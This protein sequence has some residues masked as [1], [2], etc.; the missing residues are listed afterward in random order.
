[1]RKII[2]ATLFF[3]TQ[4][5]AGQLL[6]TSP[7]SA[8]GIGDPINGD[9]SRIFSIGGTSAAVKDG[10]NINTAN[11][12]SYS[13]LRYTN[14]D[15][16][17]IS[18][19]LR[20]QQGNMEYENG[21]TAFNYI[22]TS[23][24]LANNLSMMMGIR[25]HTTRGFDI[26]QIESYTGLDGNPLQTRTRF[27][28]SGGINNA[29]IGAGWEP[30]SKGLSVGFNANF[31]FGGNRDFITN[32]IIDLPNSVAT[33]VEQELNI[34]AWQFET[35]LQYHREIRGIE[36][37]L[38]GTYRFG[39]TLRQTLT[40]QLLAVRLGAN[41]AQVTDTLRSNVDIYAPGYL[42]SAY[43]VGFSIG[44]RSEERPEQYGWTIAGDYR[45]TFGSEF[46]GGMQDGR[47][48]TR[49]GFVDAARISIGATFIPTLAIGRL[50]RS[51]Q[52]WNRTEYRLGF[53]HDEGIISIN[54]TQISAFGTSFG[55]AVP[56]KNRAMGPNE[57]RNNMINFTVAV[58]S[59]GTTDNNLVRENFTQFLIGITLSDKWFDKYKY[60]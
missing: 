19:N 15:L 13:R 6:G 45:M 55:I 27:Q 58:G 35:G 37:G 1:M 10:F 31:F 3:S 28:G 29:I 44:K 4:F 48:L 21:Y 2:L 39:N 14:F 59:R 7:Y 36:Y 47:S 32:S 25:P 12:A 8:L 26:T 24:P 5:V 33:R 22:L 51:K 38:G 34:R 41:Q 20:Q 52:F 16:G 43:S 11:P 56:L 30:F 18:T 42:H 46:D 54:N 40:E 50:D 9:A 57:V 49:G 23:F 53:F 17:V 60:R